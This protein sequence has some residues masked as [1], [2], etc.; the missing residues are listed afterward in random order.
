[1]NKMN[2]GALSRAL[3]NKELSS[4][5]LTMYYI[6]N[7]EKLE[8]KVGAYITE[9]FEKALE[10]AEAVDEKRL[11]GEKLS[12]LAGI[13]YGVKDNI[14]TKGIKTTCASKMLEGYVPTFDAEVIN[15]L[16]DCVILGKTNMD[17]FGM[18]SG[19]ENS[20]FKKT[21]N[22]NN[23]EFVPGGSSGGSAAGASSG[24]FPFAL[25]SDTGGSVRLPAA[26]CGVCAIR[27]TYG[28]VS[29]FG[30]I[31]FASSM[32]QIG[33]I[34]QSVLD[35]ALVM[36][37]IS[38]HD[39]K[40]MTS[41]KMPVPDYL[42]GTDTS[43][44]GMKFA[45]IKELF[46]GASKDSREAVKRAV[47]TLSE[48]GA[49]VESVSLRHLDYALCAYYIISS[50]EA[51]SNLARFDGVR[52]GRRCDRYEDL[53]EMYK[54]SRSEGFGDEV[55]R[56]IMLGTFVL[57]RGYYDKYYEKARSVRCA[58][59]SELFGILKKYDCIIAP[60]SVSGAYKF[61]EYKDNPTLC[62][63]EDLINVPSSLAGLPSITVPIFKNENNMSFSVQIIGNAFDEKTILKAGHTLE[64]SING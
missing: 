46:E 8:D 4:K 44:K 48:Q 43:V 59:S 15:R 25:G 2:L 56:R 62:Y 55:K 3:K 37:Q 51:S 18:G 52:F 45:V 36:T 49:F 9:C 6:K 47:N 50:A 5:E 61:G 28:R 10:Q 12:P 34:A 31:P 53:E 35:L 20:F 63:N 29:R 14:S 17:E 41:S 58:V 33:V 22:P 21:Y 24:E 30:L 23:P 38:G 19:C 7:S 1:M 40:D 11:K 27:P 54:R 64:V 39:K 26:F 16:S 57:S 42:Q 32:D 13:P 60:S